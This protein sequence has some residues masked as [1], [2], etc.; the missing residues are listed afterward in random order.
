MVSRAT[1]FHLGNPARRE[2]RIANP[3]L[4]SKVQ[5]EVPCGKRKPE[6][7]LVNNS[8]QPGDAVV[9]FLVW[10]GKLSVKRKNPGQEECAGWLRIGVS[11]P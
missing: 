9:K 11:G 3:E 10:P 8:A 6:L 1:E 2:A 4:F 7:K 5:S